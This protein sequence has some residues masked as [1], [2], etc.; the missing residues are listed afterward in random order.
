MSER[1]REYNN[2]LNRLADLKEALKLASRPWH[3]IDFRNTYFSVIPR[4]ILEIIYK[5]FPGQW[6]LGEGGHGIL[7]GCL[8]CN[9]NIG[10]HDIMFNYIRGYT[11]VLCQNCLKGYVIKKTTDDIWVPCKIIRL[12]DAKTGVEILVNGLFFNNTMD[13]DPIKNYRVNYLTSDC[14]IYYV[15]LTNGDGVTIIDGRKYIDAHY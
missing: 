3:L 8:H 4:D 2:K 11:A 9:A 1:F 6:W 12:I 5:M 13:M 7:F 14:V 15:H 10:Y